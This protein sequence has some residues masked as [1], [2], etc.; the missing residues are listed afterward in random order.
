MI[1]WWVEVEKKWD[2]GSKE[3]KGPDSALQNT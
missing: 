1:G 2:G 3:S